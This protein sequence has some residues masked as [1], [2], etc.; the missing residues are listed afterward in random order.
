MHR[1]LGVLTIPI[2]AAVV[3]ILLSSGGCALFRAPVEP[4]PPPW[5][6][7]SPPPLVEGVE[8]EGPEPLAVGVPP[9]PGRYDRDMDV[10]HY[11]VELVIPPENDRVSARTTIRYLREVAGPHLVTLDF[12]GM[13]VEAV[14][15]GGRALDF[16]HENGLLQFAAPGSPGVF[17][18]LQVEIMTRGVPA[19]GLLLRDNV[20][21]EATAFADNWPDRAR[22]WFPSKDHLSDRA[23]VSFTVH[24]PARR[25]VVANGVQVAGPEPAD[26]TRTGG[27]PDLMTWRWE[28]TVPIPTH[29]MVVGV[30]DMEV[31]DLGTA[32]CGQ[33]PASPMPDGCVEVTAW[34]FAPD[35]AH[36]RRVFQ[37]TPEMVDL[38]VDM[39]GPYP[40]EKLAHVQASTRFGVME[41]ASVIF[42]PEEAIS[43]GRDLVDEVAQEIVHQWFG[44][45]VTP[46]DW[47]HLWLSE[48]FAGYFGP[49][50]WEYTMDR[51]EL[52]DRM[53]AYR[54]RV[55]DASEVRDRPVVDRNPA[56]LLDLRNANSLE[57]GA[58]ALHMLRWV[59]GDRAFFQ[60]VRRFYQ[61][62]SGGHAST[63][64]F[65]R[66]MEEVHGE[67]LEWF[68]RQWLHAPGYPEY[69]VEWSWNSARN[70]VHLRVRQEQAAE[71]PT[72]RMPMEVEFQLDGGVHRQ[73]L[74][75]D[76]RDW[77]RTLPLP[78][79][80]VAVRL[81]P[82]GWLLARIH[83]DRP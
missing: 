43:Q 16:Y 83:D 14:T 54:G 50:F 55:L 8:L 49:Y 67:P 63:D 44:N 5:D 52:V 64:D 46:A 41:N 24:A 61:A 42:Y 31:L 60:G 70:E 35:T 4:A 3:A 62:H 11:D 29:L 78:S 37:R 26:T 30:A 74:M 15:W 25:R 47:S 32:A 72:F 65:Q 48:G 23:T 77:D 82:D 12:T 18:T 69:R 66:I 9:A 73:V 38:Y 10:I 59:T 40:F 2:L 39:F 36:A 33:A 13:R 56:N 51:Q 57:K 71:W 1:P 58:L 80:P 6:S 22:F 28:N 81:D 17:D 19:D 45:S 34:A 79:R 75:M 68:F 76:G 53:D 27:L 21:G 7:I 20:H